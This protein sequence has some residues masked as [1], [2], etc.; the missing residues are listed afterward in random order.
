M[1]EKSTNP[2]T[3]KERSETLANLAMPSQRDS[4]SE[5]NNVL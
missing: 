5:N 4:G 1:M 2:V 3:I